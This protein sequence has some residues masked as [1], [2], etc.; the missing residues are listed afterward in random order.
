MTAQNTHDPTCAKFITLMQNSKI[1]KYQA[2]VVSVSI[3]DKC[4]IVRN[5]VKDGVPKEIN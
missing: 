4:A 5:M 2:E 3:I 1:K